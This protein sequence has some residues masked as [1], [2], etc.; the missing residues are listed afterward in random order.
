MLRRF[1]NRKPVVPKDYFVVR[2]A[3]D[4][5][6]ELHNAVVEWRIAGHRLGGMTF[7]Q[8]YAE[9]PT[10]RSR[11]QAALVVYGGSN[12]LV[13]ISPEVIANTNSPLLLELNADQQLALASDGDV[14]TGVRIGGLWFDV[15]AEGDVQTA[16]W[17]QMTGMMADSGALRVVTIGP[18]AIM[19]LVGDPEAALNGIL[20]FPNR[21]TTSEYRFL[22]ID[23][24]QFGRG[25]HFM[26]IHPQQSRL[27]DQILDKA[28]HV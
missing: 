19:A 6:A 5:L 27:Y 2:H 9:P 17:L 10:G 15:Q 14:E 3:D 12:L 28:Q 24:T 22:S 16:Q 26:V 11:Q 23:P 1:F 25:L 21:A 20:L 4:V 8:L 7:Y 18:D 13:F